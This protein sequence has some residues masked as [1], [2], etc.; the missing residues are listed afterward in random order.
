MNPFDLPGPTFLIFYVGLLA[1]ALFGAAYYRK[2]HETGEPSRLDLSDPY[3]I[4]FLRGGPHE[5]L[6]VAVINLVDRGLLKVDKTKI[7]RTAKADP[8]S[9][10]KAL[11]RALLDRAHAPV[12]A[13]TL[14]HGLEIAEA[15]SSYRTLLKNER[16]LPSVA[17]TSRRLLTF[18]ITLGIVLGIGMIKLVIALGRG[19]HNVGFLTLLMCISLGGAMYVCFPRL[20][21]KGR[22]ALEDLRA[23]YSRLRYRARE[24]QPGGATIEAVML[25]A[26][27][28]LTALEGGAFGYWKT[29]FPRASQGGSSCGSSCGGGGGCGGGGCGGGCGGCGG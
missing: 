17:Q 9:A 6:R 5:S 29:L 8:S 27:F 1:A 11:E 12:D 13:A 10:R 28:G 18:V 16:M 19:H 20:T 24:I 14:F 23:L 22:L 21:E 2:T 15:L 25:A 7:C 4:A 26:V 3:L